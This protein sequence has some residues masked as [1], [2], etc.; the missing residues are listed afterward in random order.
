MCAGV[1]GAAGRP[2]HNAAG[3]CRG[4]DGYGRYR[5]G[6]AGRER[7]DPRIDPGTFARV[8]MTM[9]TKD[10][11]LVA[12]LS[13]IGV[14]FVGVV[15]MMVDG[16]P[17]LWPFIVGA[18]M[19]VGVLAAALLTQL[20]ARWT[21][22]RETPHLQRFVSIPWLVAFVAIAGVIRAAPTAIGIAAICGSCSCST[23]RSPKLD[24]SAERAARIRRGLVAM[25]GCDCV[26][27]ESP[28]SSTVDRFADLF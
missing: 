2:S 7:W 5:V 4:R 9:R 14:G 1:R 11:P 6:G 17:R 28:G 21:K 19:L 20:A 8:D 18:S 27:T 16:A 25:L 10:L 23:L 22:G 13:F 3:P 26:P 15:L 24:S 12:G